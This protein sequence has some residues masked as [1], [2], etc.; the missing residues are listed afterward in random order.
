MGDIVKRNQFFEHIFKS[1]PDI[2]CLTDTRFSEQIHNLIKNETNYYCYFNSL[3][4]NSRGVAVLVNKRS[5]LKIEVDVIDN[6]G[7][8][9]WLKCEFD[10]Q[11]FLL[12]VLYGPNDDSPEF[13]E[14][15]FTHYTNSGFI[16]CILT[17]DFNVTLN[18]DIDNYGYNSPRNPRARRSLNNLMGNYGFIDAFRC[19]N[20]NKRLFTWIR[21]GGPQR[22]RLDMFLL[23]E[24]LR[25][26]IQSQSTFPA[27]RSDH[28]PIILAI[29]FSQFVRGKGVWKHNSEL[30]KDI[31][32]VNAINHTIKKSF[33]KYV[34][35]PSY[36]NF[37]QDA[38]DED[39]LS[40]MNLEISAIEQMEFNIDPH[41]L[42]DMILNDIRNETITFSTAKKR[43]H[44]SI[45]NELFSNL[46][47]LQDKIAEGTLHPNI[48][49]ELEQTERQY[50]EF[51]E[52]QNRKTYFNS[53]LLSKIEGEKPTKYFLNIEKK[54]STQKYIS[55]LT[56]KDAEG[57][58]TNITSQPAIE[59]EAQLYYKDLF[60]NKDE[61]ISLEI[62]DFLNEEDTHSKLNP[63]QVQ[64]LEKDITLQELTDALKKT[65]NGSTP[66]FSGFTYAFYK[67]FWRYLG[68]TILN[69]MKYSFIINKL[70]SS[71][72]IG[73]ISLLPKGE[74]PKQFLENWRPITLQ[75]SIYKLMSSVISNRINLVLPTIIHNDQSGFVNGRYIGDCIRNTFD[76]MQWAK[77]KKKTGLLLLIDFHKAFDSVSFKY[78]DKCL[79]FFGFGNNFKKWIN[80]LLHNFKACI[81]HAGNISEFF[82]V[83]RGCRQGDPI[84]AALFVLSI[85]ILC[86]KLR[87]SSNVTGFKVENKEILL[88]LYADDCSIFLEYNATNLE[89]TINI[90]N[91]FY[92][93]SGLKI[94]LSKSQCVIFGNLPID[95]YKLC[96]HIKLK[97]DQNFKLLGV[98]FDGMLENMNANYEH[99]LKEMRSIMKSWQY[100]F[101]TPLGRACISKTLLLSK[102]SHISFVI[103]GLD[104]KRLKEIESEIYHF[105]WGGS[106]KVARIDAKQPQSR[107]GLG[108]PDI[109][110]SFTAF[111]FS[112][113]RRMV[114]SRS[115]W[116][117]IFLLNLLNSFGIDEH[118]FFT[119]IGT[120]E[121]DKI[122]KKFPN[123]FWKDCLLSIKP[124]MLEHLKNAPEYFSSY[125]IWGSSLFV[126]N[127]AVCNKNL[128]NNV[129]SLINTPSDILIYSEPQVR[130]LTDAEFYD[131]Y[132]QLP[133][134]LSYTSVKQIIREALRRLGMSIERLPLIYPIFPPLLQIINFSVKGCNK[135]SSLLKVLHYS[136]S[137]LQIR[138][139]KW[140]EELGAIQGNFFWEKCY[141]LNKNI[142]FD[143]KLK[144]LQYQI[145]RGTLKTNRIVSKFNREVSEECT[146][147]MTTIESI[148]HLFYECV[149]VREFISEIYNIFIANWTDIHLIPDKKDFIF[150]FRNIPIFSSNNLLI[151]YIKY[152]IWKCRCNQSNLSLNAFISWFKFELYVTFKAYKNDKRLEYL[153]DAQYRIE[154]Y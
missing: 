100:R 74:K 99:K 71:Q 121:Y 58:E 38:T 10:N 3:S 46:K 108:F 113:F 45:E 136:N 92:L 152:F 86:I 51:R 39:F 93:V 37:F 129:G 96:N 13:F 106:E 89:N 114:N 31:E 80:I 54:L 151:L 18:H 90:L 95:N 88:S 47:S 24:S 9:L 76:I 81:N 77:C 42:L 117:Y 65:K 103:P 135:W 143:N 84:A 1:K 75:N 66:G 73:I 22:A 48:F 101:I 153:N 25:P 23:T 79:Q 15:I 64:L 12:G 26:F 109:H 61:F 111:R 85:E 7:N 52:L 98:E 8:L 150:G 27:F 78:I 122:A 128:F 16:N 69:A 132:G 154:F 44:N 107:G 144:W 118:T 94:H 6:E 97:W 11:K 105:I 141:G 29:D 21:K 91:D 33:A 148:T 146:F 41:T 110:A 119:A 115:A 149:L 140:E 133:D 116:K 72:T 20:P 127:S 4:S 134:F 56:V 82:E 14:N 63:E 123:P 60:S 68:K 2:L 28:S 112:W 32:Y 62:D 30:L 126:R 67:C 130:F 131:K 124:L 125:P 49:E 87:S 120:A 83:S 35:N 19:L 5:C 142:F 53:R 40:F 34:I 43:L 50:N 70:P 137:N 59:K 55:L 102:L 138:E 104:K 36:D 139:R 147:C 145:T 17:G 57:R